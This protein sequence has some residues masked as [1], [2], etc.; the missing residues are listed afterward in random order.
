MTPNG[1][2]SH[3]TP[4]VLPQGVP[5]VAE[6]TQLAAVPVRVVQALEALPGLLV[7]GFRVRRVDVVVTLAGL[8][9]PPDLRGIAEVSRGTLVTSGALWCDRSKC[10]ASAGGQHT[11]LVPASLLRLG[12]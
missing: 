11:P 6:A 9:R 4:A 8:T 2:D 3:L 5:V 7:A 1:A 10:K 12:P